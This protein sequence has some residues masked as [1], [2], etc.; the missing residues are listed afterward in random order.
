MLRFD[1]V[2]IKQPNITLQINNQI[3][4]PAAVDESIKDTQRDLTAI[5]T[6]T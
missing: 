2:M 3:I 1:Q 4:K 6:I 5:K